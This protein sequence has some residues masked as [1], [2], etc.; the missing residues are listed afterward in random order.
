MEW[1]RRG[2][3]GPLVQMAQ[4]ALQRAGW[5]PGPLDGIFG[6]RTEQAV[7]QFQRQ[8]QLLQ[9]GIVGTNTWEALQPFLLGYFIRRAQR[10]DTF[11]QLAKRFGLPVELLLAANPTTPAAQ[12]AI[13]QPLRI[14][15][16]FP[17]VSGEIPMTSEFLEWI[18]R[19]LTVRYPFLQRQVIGE[20]G[21]GRPLSSLQ[22]GEG[23]RSQFWNAAHHANEWITTPILLKFLEE[24]ARAFVMGESIEGVAAG[25][26]FRETQLH[27]VPLVNPDGVDL[28]TGLLSQ[29]S[30]AYQK[31]RAIAAN[32]PNIPFPDG[33][34]AD[35]SGVDLNLNYPAEWEK[36]RE[37]KFEQGYTGP[38]PRDFVGEAPLSQ[39]ETKAL[40]DYTNQEDFQLTL[41]YH[42]QGEVIYWK[43]ADFLPP[44]SLR[45]GQK[46]AN[47][48]G[49]QLELT[50]PNS[51]Y[52]G[53]KDWFIQTTD[54]PGYTIEAGLG[55]NPLPLS[56]FDEIYQVNKPLLVT[57]LVE[58]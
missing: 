34:K 13:G 33:W 23:T 4:L 54:R 27:V 20:S 2:S 55:T 47:A 17:V 41:S 16:P 18:I 10:G 45:I 3:R 48:S 26:L 46:L 1:I 56:Q 39:K 11:Y 42:T 30:E 38:A 25:T 22:M 24:Y 15:Y 43:F 52:A 51:A 32:Y 36:A 58:G 35:L 28:V 5:Q 49:Y 12:I 44:N 50:P 29:E 19:G 7:R 8:Q 53:Y 6:P 31:A 57:A 37:I 40:A 14:P 21:L 9:D